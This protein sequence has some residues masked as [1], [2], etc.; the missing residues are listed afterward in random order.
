ME[1]AATK[2]RKQKRVNYVPLF[3]MLLPGMIY[4]IINNYLPMYGITIAFK[5]L[6]YS[7]GIWGS[8]W[9]GLKNFEYLFKTKDAAIMIRN[10]LCY[11]LVFIFWRIG[12]CACHCSYDDGDRADEDCKIYPA[13]DLLSKHGIDHHCVLSCLCISGC[14]R[15]CE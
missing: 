15:L 9:V 8:P 12:T 1:K 7:K 14:K 2:K 13:G 6:D 4:L 11:N 5:N 10:T 3:L